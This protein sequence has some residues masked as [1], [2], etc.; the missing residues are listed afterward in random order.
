MSA[1]K[2]GL[3]DGN[4]YEAL[5]LR[6]YADSSGGNENAL[7]FS[8]NSSSVYHSQYTFGSTTTWGTMYKFLD[9]NNYSSYALPLSGG[10][11]TD[12]LILKAG[13]FTAS[14]GNSYSGGRYQAVAKPNM[15]LIGDSTY[16]LSTIEFIS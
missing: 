3:S 7:L 2:L 4:Y 12:T 14:N 9:S 10:T 1:S 11:I 5:I 8:K 15:R 16:G 6:G 13:A